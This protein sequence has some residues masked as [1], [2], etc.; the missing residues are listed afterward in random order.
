MSPRAPIIEIPPL[1]HADTKL[2]EGKPAVNYLAHVAENRR[3]TILRMLDG[4]PGYSLNDAV[5]QATLEQFAHKVSRDVVSS[6]FSWLSEQGLVDVE[7]VTAHVWV[8]TLTQRGVDVANGRA[9]HPGVARPS[10]RR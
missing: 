2:A 8:A 5:V 3:L 10:P 6:D 4:T 1:S 9:E 7:A